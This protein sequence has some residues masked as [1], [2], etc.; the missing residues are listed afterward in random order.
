ME[1]DVRSRN[2]AECSNVQFCL[3]RRFVLC[4]TMCW[5]ISAW[6][7]SS[8]M[9]VIE[10]SGEELLFNESRVVSLVQ[11]GVLH[12][13]GPAFA[14]TGFDNA[15]LGMFFEGG[16]RSQPRQLTIGNFN[17][18]FG[19]WSIRA[20]GDVENFG[21][22]LA[23]D[24][25]RAVLV[26][27]H[28]FLVTLSRTFTLPVNPRELSF[29]VFIA[30]GFDL[31]AS[32]IPDAFEVQL[33]DNQGQSVVPTWSPE[34]TSFF[35]IQEDV[36]TNPAEAFNLAPGVTIE[37]IDGGGFPAW[38]VRLNLSGVPGGSVVTLYNDLIGADSDT[39]SGVTV[40]NFTIDPPT[41]DAGGPYAE[42]CLDGGAQ[43]RLD[44]RGSRVA[45]GRPTSVQ[46]RSDCPGAVFDD[47][48]SLTPVLTIP[49]SE[50][51]GTVCAV[52][53]QVSDGEYTA[54]DSATVNLAG[55]VIVDDPLNPPA[56]L[57]LNCTGGVTIET[58][59]PFGE[60]ATPERVG[61]RTPTSTGGTAPVSITSTVPAVFPDGDSTV[62]FIATDAL[63]ETATC[64]ITVAVIRPN[65]PRYQERITT[66]TTNIGLLGCGACAPMGLGTMFSLFGGLAVLKAEARR[67]RRR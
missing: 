15:R 46:W 33:L 49:Q 12:Q 11:V 21:S 10:P 38:R 3:W 55:P 63:G 58:R 24:R 36:A 48:T 34:A 40:G 6:P 39:G 42:R 30:P 25:G 26:E 50:C 17:M 41:A 60:P 7:L 66:T 18:G 16:N 29:D 19:G 64:T 53:I 20:L 14:T 61:V 67:S 56:P 23:D 8:A 5:G 32:T 59:L 2:Q 62:T 52:E 44:G 43:I 45:E 51:R 47:P 27:N 54:T 13:S 37:P 9:A 4:P 22:V 65:D 57:S 28:S 31:T 35:N 1:I